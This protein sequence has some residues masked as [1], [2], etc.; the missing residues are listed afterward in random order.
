MHSPSGSRVAGYAVP[1]PD[2]RA[3][4]AFRFGPMQ[5]N[6]GWRAEGISTIPNAAGERN[7]KMKIEPNS[8]LVMIGD[9]ITE[10]GREEPLR[11][12]P[13]GLIG[14]GYV[15][16]VDSLIGAA[17]PAHRLR[18]WN[19]GIGGNTVRD[20]AKR[21]TK[22][23]LDLTPDW[24]SILIGINDVWGQFDPYLAPGGQ[25]SIGEYEETLEKLIRETR[26][27]L[28]GLILMTPYFVEADRK[29]PLRAMMDRYGDVVRALAPMYQAV[30][31]DTQAAI[32]RV[33]RDLAPDDLAS[34]RVHIN[35]LGHMIL[36]RA[37]LKAVDYAW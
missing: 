18:I 12:E 25:V 23:V 34:D 32:D 6:C 37:F 29:V 1:L 9:S 36:A 27:R 15:Q 28:K 13:D 31:V 33:L 22:H 3:G 2:F 26:P 5:H 8:T 10:W 20:L 4:P 24:L 35:E 11:D 14:S 16:Y 7:R 19:V 21:W 17:Y 30:L